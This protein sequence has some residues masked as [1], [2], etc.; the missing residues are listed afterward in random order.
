MR[1]QK[2][3]VLSYTPAVSESGL[4]TLLLAFPGSLGGGSRSPTRAMKPEKQNMKLNNNI[5]II[6]S[7]LR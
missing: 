6:N 1:Y 2:C 3:E 4:L 5:T 7:C